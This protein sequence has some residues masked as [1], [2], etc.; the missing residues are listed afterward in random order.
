MSVMV[1]N[2]TIKENRARQRIPLGRG[3]LRHRGIAK[4]ALAIAVLV[5]IAALPITASIS[6]E[7]F[8]RSSSVAMARL[9]RLQAVVY[10]PLHLPHTTDDIFDTPAKHPRHRFLQSVLFHC[11]FSELAQLLAS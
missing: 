11:E 7:D 9:G 6:T 2:A 1:I 3:R 5:L 8:A 10:S 4:R